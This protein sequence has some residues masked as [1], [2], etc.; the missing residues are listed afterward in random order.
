MRT[1]R[2]VKQKMYYSMP[3]EK[4]TVYKRDKDGNIVYV[5]MANGDME[6]ARTGEEINVYSQAVEFHNSITGDLT[7]DELA[8]FG[9]DA[10]GKAKMTYH[11]GQYPFIVGT[12]IWKDTEVTYKNGK[13]D[14]KTADYEVI[15]ILTTG[16]HFT[17][18]L[19]KEVVK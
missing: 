5:K 12:R 15:G 14:E 1:P 4:I 7:A 2:R 6:P 18:C 11:K 17:R 13:V 3:D 10:S 9:A 8:A 19:L 16:R